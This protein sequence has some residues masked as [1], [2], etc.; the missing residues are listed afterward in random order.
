MKVRIAKKIFEAVAAYKFFET[1]RQPYTP[2]QQ[3]KA[4]KALRLPLHERHM[5]RICNKV[6]DP[7]KEKMPWEKIAM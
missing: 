7:K 1:N 5:V 3:R 4:L 6:K 2:Q